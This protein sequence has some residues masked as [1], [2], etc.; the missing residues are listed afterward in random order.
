MGQNLA[1]TQELDL[2]ARQSA[3][4]MREF[5]EGWYSKANWETR[6]QIS[7]EDSQAFVAV[8][9]RKLRMELKTAAQ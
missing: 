7:L 6:G 4:I 8:A 1:F 9:L 2:H 5:A 3:R